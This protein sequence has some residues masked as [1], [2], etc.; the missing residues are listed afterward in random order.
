MTK[1]VVDP[2][3]VVKIEQGEADRAAGTLRAHDL[4]VQLTLDA[5][6]IEQTGE[7]VLRNLRAHLTIAAGPDRHR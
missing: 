3:E 1:G 2:F 6:V 5:G 7:A 4:D